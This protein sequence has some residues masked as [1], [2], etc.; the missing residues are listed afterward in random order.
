MFANCRRYIEDARSSVSFVEAD[1]KIEL[2]IETSRQITSQE[3]V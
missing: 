2:L 3:I 1:D